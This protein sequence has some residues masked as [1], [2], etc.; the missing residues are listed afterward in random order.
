[1]IELLVPMF[2]VVGGAAAIAIPLILHL[3]QSSRTV[4][5]PYSTIRFLQLAQKKASQKIRM[6]NILLW[7][8]RTLF[9]LALAAAFAMPML[10][11]K[12]IGEWAGRS[13]RDVAIV[14]DGSYS[15]DYNLGRTT[16]WEKAISTSISVLEGLEEQDRFCIFVARE[17]PD[18]LIEQLSSDREEAISRLKALEYSQGSSNLSLAVME[19]NDVLR[20][21]KQRREKEIHIITDTQALPWE[22]IG[23]NTSDG[24]GTNKTTVSMS[25]WDAS[26][27]DKRTSVFVSLL[28]A[29][30]PENI[31]PVSVE[32][33][34]ALIM[35]ESSARVTIRLGY[36]G[37][38][39]STA[40]TLY[41]DDKEIASRAMSADSAE[42][43]TFIIPPLARGRHSARIELPEDN[44]PLDNTFHFMLK[45]EDQLPTLCVGSRDDLFFLRAALNA[46]LGGSGS[47]NVKTV[48]PGLIP[49]DELNNYSTIFLC[50]AVP[51]G[52]SEVR[53]LEKFA[54]AGGLLVIFPGDKGTASD[55]SAL[56][57][58]PGTPSAIQPVASSERRGL[59]NWDMPY[60][61]VLAGLGD[62]A[63][64][65]AIA[66]K[67]Q[68][69]F[70]TFVSRAQKMISQGDAQPFLVGRPFGRGFVLMFSVTANRSWSD[71]PLSPFFLPIVHQVVQFGSG[72]GSF[73]PYVWCTERLP[74]EQHLPEARAENELKSPDG[75]TIPIRSSVV[76]GQTILHVENV[77]QAGMYTLLTEPALAVN[78]DRDE[79][80][81]TPVDPTGLPKRIGV[82][83]VFISMNE[84]ELAA[85]LEEARIGRT[86]GEQLLWLALIL[87]IIEFFYANRLMKTGG[88]L[89]EKMKVELSG[90]IS[91]KAA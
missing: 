53:A 80:D 16:A 74:L 46:E 61:P 88:G 48:E 12:S 54:D 4:R 63:S 62:S 40:A 37:P 24:S 69:F 32:L 38:T 6:E 83:N 70:E 21:A 84:E 60:H 10:R 89:S 51:M 55:Y 34:P 59:L 39:A 27:I 87:A 19:A 13:A 31:S 91:E 81:L 75:E 49:L 44:L 17:N 79:S 22:G 14:I 67:Q 73:T 66:I 78:M 52:A 26:K 42:P 68:L 11:T 3:I 76:E 18:A 64:A 90:K 85:Q 47:I 30:S 43:L 65:P 9:L 20:E 7:L 58:L 71:F 25:H 2:M 28:G 33:E 72:V 29:E 57:F 36:T 50:N 86:F 35:A 8:I 1:M 41:I 77:D 45:V 5:I 82:E 23:E 15:M 56:P